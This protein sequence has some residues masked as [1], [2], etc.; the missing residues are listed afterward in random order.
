MLRP[1]TMPAAP[2]LVT[3]RELDDLV[4]GLKLRAAETDHRHRLGEHPG[5]G[6]GQA[7]DAEH[8]IRPAGRDRGGRIPSG[9]PYPWKPPWSIATMTD[10]PSGRNNRQNRRSFPAAGAELTWWVGMLSPWRRIFRYGIPA[11]CATGH[12][13]PPAL[14]SAPSASGR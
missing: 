2:A 5:G 4:L 3:A 1:N 11:A 14:P 8:A 7:P 12:W 10:R 6:S 9:G 13:G